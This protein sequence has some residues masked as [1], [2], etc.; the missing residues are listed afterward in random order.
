M[1]LICYYWWD[2]VVKG[3]N[4][5]CRNGLEPGGERAWLCSTSS[6]M[7]KTYHSKAI[8]EPSMRIQANFW[9]GRES[10]S[11]D[12]S[13]NVDEE[14]GDDKDEDD[15]DFSVENSGNRH[16]QLYIKQNKS[17]RI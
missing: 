4:I 1:G 14:G 5:A 16:G 6:E 8:R 11:L 10:S 13:K 7:L 15:N 17:L 2:F 3:W 9:N 12:G